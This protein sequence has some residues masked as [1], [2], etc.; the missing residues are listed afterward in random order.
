[1]L[2]TLQITVFII[3]N[4]SAISYTFLIARILTA[5]PISLGGTLLVA[6]LVEALRYEPEGRG[7]DS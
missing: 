5:V 3:M 7:F 2:I 1:M 4:T 6:Q